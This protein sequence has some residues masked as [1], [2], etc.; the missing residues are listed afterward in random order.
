[1]GCRRRVA[2]TPGWATGG[3]RV[4]VAQ[5]AGRCPSVPAVG[6]TAG[7]ASSPAWLPGASQLGGSDALFKLVLISIR[8]RG[9]APGRA[10]HAS[11]RAERRPP[12]SAANSLRSSCR[13]RAPL[14]GPGAGGVPWDPAVSGRRANLLPR[15]RGVVGSSCGPPSALES[16]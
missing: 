2:S 4:A 12:L 14:N 1:L 7:V 11:G 5:G 10:T 15:S 6:L 9:G 16:N 13:R 8:D 3:F